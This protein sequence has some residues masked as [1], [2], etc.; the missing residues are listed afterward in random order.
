MNNPHTKIDSTLTTSNLRL[1]TL[2]LLELEADV[3]KLQKSLEQ[4]QL[5]PTLALHEILKVLVQGKE[6]H[7]PFEWTTQSFSYHREHFQ[8]HFTEGLTGQS[9]DEDSG[10]H[11]LA[12]AICRLMFMLNIR[13]GEDKN[14]WSNRKRK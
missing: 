11:N 13:L 7:T 8:E 2:V 4:L 5:I 3:K 9:I 6:T 10:L 12:H 1:S 14:N